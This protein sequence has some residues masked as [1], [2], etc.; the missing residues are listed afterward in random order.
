MPFHVL[1]VD[2]SEAN[3]ILL[4]DILSGDGYQVTEADCGEA[5]LRAIAEAPPDLVLLDVMM[6]DLSGVEVC[7]RIR[8]LASTRDIAVILVTALT[9]RGA[10]F[11]GFEAG[12]DDYLSK[13]VDGAELRLRVRT[14]ARLRRYRNLLEE[15]SR[16]TTLIQHSPDA[17][18]LCGDGRIVE[19]NPAA[20]ALFATVLPIGR[21][22]AEVVP[23][24]AAEDREW[25]A[26]TATTPRGEPRVIA[27]VV[28][29]VRLIVEVSRSDHR[30]SDLA[31]TLVL[32]RDVTELA[33]LRTVTE[34][35]RRHEAIATV[36]TGI[37]HDFRNYLTAIQM[38]L[39]LLDRQ[40]PATLPTGRQII[41]E[42]Q[43]QIDTGV[44]LTHRVTAVA[45]G[46]VS[47]QAAAVIDL[48]T[49]LEELAPLIRHWADPAELVLEFEPADGIRASRDDVVQLVSNLVVNAG[50][51][52]GADG[53]VVV[54]VRAAAT[55]TAMATM[56]E[57]S[58]NGC[59]MDGATVERIF[60]PYFSTKAARG[61]TGLGLATVQG[62]VTRCGAGIDVVSAPGA[63]TTFTVTWP[64]ISGRV[65]G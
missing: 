24:A 32:A 58:D 19:A 15:R 51:A 43:E 3:R 14:L 41:R 28:D 12:A 56:L 17:I 11:E 37:S 53:R 9:D 63:G 59:G 42:M 60:D 46:Q 61:G 54:R 4:A 38:G 13:P 21:P 22:L 18:L 16:A 39:D 62:I 10:R 55:P 29:G 5:A 57:V 2:D 34:R 64:T 30:L 31:F 1:V 49:T 47:R 35:L 40:L 48:Q 8:A 25:L 6:P 26:G 23:A 36:A 44:A 27:I 50:Q 33:H 20:C 7:R 45:S 52:V 65:L